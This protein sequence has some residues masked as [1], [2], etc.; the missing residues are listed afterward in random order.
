M[1][2]EFYSNSQ[3]PSGRTL[4]L[5]YCTLLFILTTVFN[6]TAAFI[7]VVVTGF[8]ADVVANGVGVANTSATVPFDGNGGY[9]LIDSTYRFNGSDPAPLHSLLPSG[10]IHSA[11]TSGVDFHLESFSANNSLHIDTTG[12]PGVLTFTSPQSAS[13]IYLL[14]ASGSGAATVTYTVTFTDVSTQ[15]FST[16]TLADWYLGT[17]FAIAGIGRAN[18]MNAQPTGTAATTNP[19]LYEKVLTLSVSNYNKLI[20]SISVTRTST[21]GAVNVMAV[22]ISDAMTSVAAID[23]QTDPIL[24]NV[25]PNPVINE[26]SIV[27]NGIKIV[28]ATVKLAIYSITGEKVYTT[29]ISAGR[30]DVMVK[31]ETL[32]APGIY[33]AEADVDTKIYRA[34]FIVR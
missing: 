24:L 8:N 27:L 34:K 18:I 32:L 5:Y 4:K 17:G 7:P 25:Y 16:Q 33:M 2:T 19:R 9:Y 1:K 23:L 20:A 11:A 3:S 26:F 6:T 10:L 22:T 21:S 31:P 14:A 28:N 30:S 29:E 12:I 13:A 15:V